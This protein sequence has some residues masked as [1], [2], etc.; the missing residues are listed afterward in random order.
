[1][2]SLSVDSRPGSVCKPKASYAFLF[3]TK[4]NSRR[5]CCEIQ[6]QKYRYKESFE[7]ERLFIFSH[8]MFA[9]EIQSCLQYLQY[10][11]R[12]VKRIAK[13]RNFSIPSTIPYIGNH[14]KHR[15]T[16]LM[17]YYCPTFHLL[18]YKFAFY[19]QVKY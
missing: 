1:M 15:R 13:I 17:L 10:D 9:W 6:S 12:Q 4:S 16:L 7:I 5:R 3:M 19:R 2:S 11:H 18:E 14:R 8:I